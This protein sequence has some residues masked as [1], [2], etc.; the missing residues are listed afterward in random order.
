MKS[1]GTGMDNPNWRRRIGNAMK[2]LN[3]AP[4]MPKRL[5]TQVGNAI[6]WPPTTTAHAGQKPKKAGR[7]GAPKSTKRA[8]RSQT[9]TV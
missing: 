5:L 8:P 1:A 9:A 3:E 2:T 4:N 6:G 7:R